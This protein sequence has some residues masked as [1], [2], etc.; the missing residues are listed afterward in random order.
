MY[1]CHSEASVLSAARALLKLGLPP[2]YPTLANNPT[3]KT[4]RPESN[5]VAA[6]LSRTKTAWTGSK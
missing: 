1:A 5:G 2:S 3:V 6:R 4:S